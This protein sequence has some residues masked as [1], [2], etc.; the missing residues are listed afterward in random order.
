VTDLIHYGEPELSAEEVVDEAL[1]YKPI[2][3]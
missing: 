1:R 2:V 3:L